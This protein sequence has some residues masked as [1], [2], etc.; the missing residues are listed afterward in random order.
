M[1]TVEALDSDAT[2]PNNRVRYALV[3]R[4]KATKYF[5]IEPDTGVLR[6]RDDLRKETDSEYTVSFSIFK[7]L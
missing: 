4:G 1:D 5:H 6:V 3:G 7:G 2:S